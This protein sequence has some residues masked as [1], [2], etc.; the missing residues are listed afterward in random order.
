MK[1]VHR[2]VSATVLFVSLLAGIFVATPAQAV[3]CGGGYLCFYDN[4]NGTGFLASTLASSRAHSIC[5]AESAVINNKVGYIINNS[6]YD[7]VVYDNSSCSGASAP[8]YAWSRGAMNS[9]WNNKISS[10]F[11]AS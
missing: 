7:F 3:T 11:R 10:T 8:V 4:T 9:T 6:G 2:F 5:Y 1:F